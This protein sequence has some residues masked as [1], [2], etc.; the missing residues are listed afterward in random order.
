MFYFLIIFGIFE[1]GF[2]CAGLLSIFFDGNFKL[3]ILSLTWWCPT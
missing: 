3:L 2:I 1:A